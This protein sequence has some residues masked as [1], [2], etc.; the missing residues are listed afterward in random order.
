MTRTLRV[1]IASDA[2]GALDS[3]AAGVA[4]ARGW[5]DHAQ[6]AVVPIA[7]AGPALGGALA[8]LLD[9]ELAVTDE[10]WWLAAGDTL[11]VGTVPTGPA[12]SSAW[13]TAAGSGGIGAWLDTCLSRVPTPRRLI[14]DLTGTAALDG[15]AGLL[16]ALGATAA[17]DLA[18]GLAALPGVD[19]LSLGPVLARLAGTEVVGVVRPDE[20]GLGLL[21]LQG[22]VARRGFDARLD[23]AELLA[24]EST[25]TGWLGRLGL[26]DVPGAGASGGAAAA[27]VALGGRVVRGAALCAELARLGTTVA[28]ADVVI[29]GCTSFHI[30]NWGGELV[31][32][33][34]DLA[35]AAERA[36]LVFAV[37][38][39]VSRREMRTF[40][41]EAAHAVG[42]GPLP[43]ALTAASARVAS[44]WTALSEPRVH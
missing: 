43:E 6:V 17:G 4:M 36:C 29:T 20:T 8:G 22:A 11:A 3:H 2:I 38:S 24:A 18:G 34:A 16:G 41:V 44:S 39:T 12:G 28:L 15:G 30:G 19:R 9:G 40:G 23:P 35:V 1:A 5:A 27:V 13:D 37:E 42:I 21:G 10:G 14:I 32:Y 7:D 25:M 26:A 33:V 31:R